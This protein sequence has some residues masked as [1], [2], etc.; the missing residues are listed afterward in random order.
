MFLCFHHSHFSKDNIQLLAKYVHQ[1]F[2]A[3]TARAQT[4]VI[5]V[6]GFQ[7]TNKPPLDLP[8]FL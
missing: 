8:Q 6:L 5:L 7:Q 4:F 2:W 1:R 3:E